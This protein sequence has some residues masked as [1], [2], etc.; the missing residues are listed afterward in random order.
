MTLSLRSLSRGSVVTLAALSFVACTEAI[1]PL[2]VTP[3][4][5][6]WVGSGMA[7]ELENGVAWLTVAGAMD[8]DNWPH[9]SMQGRRLANGGGVAFNLQQAVGLPSFQAVQ[10]EC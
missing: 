8:N 2:D 3:E 6:E 9:F 4:D 5:L 7:F 10:P 1:A